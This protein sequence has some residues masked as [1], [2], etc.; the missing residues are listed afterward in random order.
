M[1]HPVAGESSPT[2]GVSRLAHEAR[3]VPLTPQG[4]IAIDAI[5]RRGPTGSARIDDTP[6]GDR[7][8]LGRDQLPICCDHWL[9][10]E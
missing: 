4:A 9:D 7:G 2:A 3:Q 6:A 1:G 5:L 10:P 8:C